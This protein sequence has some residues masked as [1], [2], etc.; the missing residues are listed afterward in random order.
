M[1][2][3]SFISLIAGLIVLSAPS[4][5]V[6]EEIERPTAGDLSLSFGVP[7]GGNDY[8]SGAAG[9]WYMASD[10]LNLGLNFGLGV[11]FDAPAS[12]WDILLAPAARFY[13]TRGGRISPFL[14]GQLNLRPFEN[15]Q[16]EV[17]LNLSL[18][19]GFG[20]EVWLID[21]LSLSGFIGLGI[22][23]YQGSASSAAIG[24]LT[25]GLT[26]NFYFDLGGGGS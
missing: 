21:E 18:L 19:G 6:A 17:D 16:A 15:D 3:T 22:D 23:V 4:P 26:A 11:N 13:L 9:M 24:T 14:L 1:N 8:A 7:S 5:S 12:G 2:R 20:A 25:S 10:N